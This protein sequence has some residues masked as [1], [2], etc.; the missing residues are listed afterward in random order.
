VLVIQCDLII[1]GRLY[2]VILWRQ[3]DDIMRPLSE[4]LKPGF[5]TSKDEFIAAIP[6]DST[7]IPYGELIHSYDVSKGKIVFWLVYLFYFGLM[8]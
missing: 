3:A 1:V 6:R 7:F 8:G 5:L 4:K 2:H